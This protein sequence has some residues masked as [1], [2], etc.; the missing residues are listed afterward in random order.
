MDWWE[1]VSFRRRTLYPGEVRGHI[2]KWFNFTRLRDS[3]GSIVRRG[4]LYPIELLAH[5]QKLFNCTAPADERSSNI[6]RRT[7]YPG[8]V[9]GHI[10]KW[11]NFTR[12]QDS[13][14]SIFRRNVLPLLCHT[15]WLS[16]DF[17]KIPMLWIP[18]P[19]ASSLQVGCFWRN[20]TS[21]RGFGIWKDNCF[22]NGIP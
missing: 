20:W 15:F 8:E 6:R 14:D 7:L 9:R 3:N 16:T 17:E 1:V 13:N 10:Q 5:V 18:F 11:F 4:V 12:L 21:Y 19:S 22:W 2:Q